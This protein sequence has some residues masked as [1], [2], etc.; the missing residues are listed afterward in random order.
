MLV[1]VETEIEKNMDI[2]MHLSNAWK[3]A[4][5]AGLVQGGAHTS[6]M[7]QQGQKQRKLLG[8][9]R[10]NG[11]LEGRLKEQS[12]S[13]KRYVKASKS[14]NIVKATLGAP[15]AE[16]IVHPWKGAVVSLKL[17]KT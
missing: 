16:I 1:F 10:E 4:D 11:K 17:S 2:T 14:T 3:C 12:C 13:E 6:I 7:F 5:P 8:V 15:F 9:D